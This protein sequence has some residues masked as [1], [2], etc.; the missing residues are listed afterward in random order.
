[1]AADGRLLFDT[2]VDS[3]GFEKGVANLGKAAIKSAAAIEGA[4]SLAAGAAVKI[5]SAYE[6]SLQKVATIAD[7]SI[8][9]I[10]SLSSSVTALSTEVGTSASELNETL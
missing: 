4:F 8:V 3:S 7:T 5:G 10:D 9:S 6:E 2:K 1:M